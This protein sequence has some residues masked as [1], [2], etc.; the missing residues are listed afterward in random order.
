[1]RTWFDQRPEKKVTYKEDKTRPTAPPFARP[2]Y[3]VLDY[4]LIPERWRYAIKDVESSVEEGMATDHY[5]LQANICLILKATYQGNQ[6]ACKHGARTERQRKTYIEEL[7]NQDEKRRQGL[8]SFR[9]LLSKT[10]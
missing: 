3:E 8:F 9:R 5:P 2:N 1:M 10:R 4:A 6:A 7:S